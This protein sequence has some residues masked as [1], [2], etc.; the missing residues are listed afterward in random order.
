MES[1]TAFDLCPF[2]SNQE[3]INAIEREL[4]GR[5]IIFKVHPWDKESTYSVG[6]SSTLLSFENTD[7]RQL[8][9]HADIVVTCNSTVMLEALLFGKKCASL[10]TGFSTNHHV[11]LECESDIGKLGDIDNWEA[12]Q[13]VVDSFLFCL[14]EKQ[15]GIDFWKSEKETRKLIHW[16]SHYDIIS[17][18]H[19]R[20]AR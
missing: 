10:G 7:L 12:D 6:S 9:I 19:Y 3:V 13:D 15:I 1:D 4:P 11:S 17:K 16:L 18:P 8:L 14:L 2:D 5:H 20:H